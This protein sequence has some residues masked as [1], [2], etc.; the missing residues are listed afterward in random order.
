MKTKFCLVGEIGG[1]ASLAQVPHAAR[2][3]AG[4]SGV[5]G[6]ATKWTLGWMIYNIEAHLNPG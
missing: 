5:N 4:G 6:G 3:V 2:A 1:K